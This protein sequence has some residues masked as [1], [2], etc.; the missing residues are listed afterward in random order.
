[1]AKLRMAAADWCSLRV[2]A[3]SLW[4]LRALVQRGDGEEF[5]KDGETWLK[6]REPRF[7]DACVEC[8]PGLLAGQLEPVK[9][10]LKKEKLLVSDPVEGNK[11]AHSVRVDSPLLGDSP[12]AADFLPAS[13]EDMADLGD[14]LAAASERIGQLERLLAEKDAE[15]A[16]CH[17]TIASFQAQLRRH[18]PPS[19]PQLRMLAGHAARLRKVIASSTP[20]PT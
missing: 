8:I 6:L 1:M 17:S 16:R 14:L 19:A 15:L 2:D 4:V 3:R 18:Q 11:W 9:K 10:W 20:K 13:P 12:S 7:F 5:T